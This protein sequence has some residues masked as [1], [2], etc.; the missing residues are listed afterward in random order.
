M[1]PGWLCCDVCEKWR[2]VDADSLNVW[3]NRFFFEGHVVAATRLLQKTESGF[4][5]RLKEEVL[6]R[7]VQNTLFTLSDLR[8]F[9]S[10]EAD[11]LEE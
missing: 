7:H 8:E 9:T 4:H 10:N 3:D 2:R 1:S 5:K 11:E 6:Q